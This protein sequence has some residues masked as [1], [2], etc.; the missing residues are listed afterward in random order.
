VT[1]SAFEALR[2][3]STFTYETLRHF[4]KR[5]PG[6]EMFFLT[7]T[8]AMGSFHAWR[9]PREVRRLCR[10]VVGRRPG[11]APPRGALVLPGTFPDI[12]STEVRLR[13]LTGAPLR[14]LLARGV[15]R[16][17][18]AH[19]LYGTAVRRRLS[20]SLRPDRYRH[21]LGVAE[22]AR[23]LARRHGLDPEKAALA[24]LLHDCGRALPDPLLPAY[25]R[26]RK[27]RVPSLREIAESNPLLLHGYVGADI[28]RR[29]YGVRD[30]AVL[31][32]VRKHALGDRTMSP[33][34]RLLYVAD[35]SSDDRGFPA[36]EIVR[37]AAFRDLGDGFR[38]AVRTK[39][40]YVLAKRA[41][42]HPLGAIVWNLAVG[43]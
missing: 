42:L 2:P 31:S 12:S 18:F 19:G 39:L 24:G 5:H 37:R 34:D 27:L 9:R 13:L 8:D 28:A 29:V 32:A 1:V 36:A 38:E 11:H 33:M 26:R 41:W 16:H 22:T 35:I 43:S 6:A 7:G 17:I 15:E 21:S 10:L 20:E 40:S 23:A 3:R 14:G 4:R 25:V 30:P